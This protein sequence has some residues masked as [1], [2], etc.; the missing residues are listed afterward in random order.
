[1]RIEETQGSEQGIVLLHGEGRTIQVGPNQI[2]FKMSG[3]QTNGA[4]SMIEYIVA[5]GFQ[6][7][8]TL[9]YHT[10]ESWTAYILE[11]T[12]GF[13]LGDRV[14]IVPAETT[15]SVP[16]GLPFNWCNAE[17]KPA[18]FLGVYSP[19]GFE[20]Y[21]EEVGDILNALPP[22]PIDMA[23]VMPQILPLW[24]KYG[25][26]TVPPGATSFTAVP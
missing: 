13:Q 25:I 11:G 9:H 4:F 15:V 2:T 14:V 12:F 17:E 18:R 10:R 19:A 20:K 3:A 26:A 21:F 5:P 16:P 7:P 1:M 23:Q 6:A 22:G 8:P 24:E